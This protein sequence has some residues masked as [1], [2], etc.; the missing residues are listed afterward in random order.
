[1]SRYDAFAKMMAR[2]VKDDVLPDIQFTD[3]TPELLG[4]SVEHLTESNM[5]A[6]EFPATQSNIHTAVDEYIS[7]TENMSEH[8]H[9]LMPIRRTADQFAKQL[10][11]G[12]KTLSRIK[13]TVTALS[14]KTKDMADSIMM[15]DASLA[16]TL[17]TTLDP[18]IKFNKMDWSKLDHVDENF[19]FNDLNSTIGV[20]A[21]KA[22][23]RAQI[24]ILVNRL[25]AAT[26]FNR[27]EL[28]DLEIN[29]DAARL[30]LNE[31][32]KR[33]GDKVTRDDVKHVLTMLFSLDM[34]KCNV[35]VNTI[36][37][38]MDDPTKITSLL[39]MVND[40]TVVLDV[41]GESTLKFSAPTVDELLHR[42][43]IIKK[44]VDM[45]A[46]MC[47]YYRTV[48]WSDAVVVPGNRLNPDS[49]VSF[50]QG[51]G[52]SLAIAQH[53]ACYHADSP[54]PRGGVSWKFIIDNREKVL[55]SAKEAVATNIADVTNRKKTIIR[56]SFIYQATDWLNKNKK[57]WSR[58]FAHADNPSKFAEAVYDSS[59]D[60]S[61]ESA[62]YKV[63]LNSCFVNTIV[64]TLYNELS[65]MYLRH[66]SA[67]GKM[68]EVQCEALDMTVY[69]NMVVKFL[70]EQ[71]MIE[72]I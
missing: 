67:G 18:D 17:E 43:S 26:D 35:A 13:S 25:P 50:R 1:M 70:L 24:S 9:D 6:V 22:P 57:N 52:S 27:P 53:L 28:K 69:A 68:T 20:E 21:G 33:V 40:F 37:E 41:V 39:Q 71:K 12:I 23:S 32:A 34:H 60:A 16:M 5:N 19:I 63:M 46:Y 58:Q 49:W 7:L 72:T 10:H 44:Y 54:V 59:I 29:K 31:V 64:G 65:D 56:D 11:T 38:S 61:L 30:T 15:E 45:A 47:A 51:G 4:T 55:S 14:E 3:V 2:A 36:R 8:Y 42:K 48:V 62:F 66:A